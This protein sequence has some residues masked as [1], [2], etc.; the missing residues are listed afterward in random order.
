M[1]IL[2]SFRKKQAQSQKLQINETAKHKNY[3]TKFP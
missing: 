3:S 1:K 2:F